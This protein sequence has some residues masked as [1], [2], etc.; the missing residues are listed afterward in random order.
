MFFETPSIYFE[1][2]GSESLREYGCSEDYRPA[3]KQIVVGV[4]LDE[5]DRPICCKLLPGNTADVTTLTS[6][7]RPLKERFGVERPIRG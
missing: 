3:R 6:G 5:E 2:E 4:V 7:V 1:G